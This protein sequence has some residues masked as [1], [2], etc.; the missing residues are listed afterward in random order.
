MRTKRSKKL[1]IFCAQV[2]NKIHHS[3]LLQES[4]EFL[5]LRPGD[6]VLDGTLGLGGHA[7][8]ILP[9]IGSGSYYGFDLD[10]DNIAFARDR[11]EPFAP[12]VTFLHDNFVHCHHRL[13]ELGVSRVDKILLDL[14]LSS[15]H[16]DDA[17]RGF[18]FRQDGPLDMRFDRS[19]EFT[20]ADWLNTVSEAELRRIFYDYGQEPYAPKLARM[21]VEERRLH[22]F[23]RTSQV[24]ELISRIMKNPH[25]QRKVATRLF[26]ALRIA[27]NDELQVLEQ[28]LGHALDL[29]APDGRIVVLTYHSLEDRIVKNV[30]RDAARSGGFHLLTKKPISPSEAEVQ[31]NPRSRSAHLRALQKISSHVSPPPSIV[32]S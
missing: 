32:R 12:R 16:V 4:L 21:V 8:A 1:Y 14:G 10:Q 20:A 23:D 25:D 26:Q 13:S 27:V 9:L 29:L 2:L 19:A 30:F 11:L 15:P 18:S 24:V 7:E 5:A 22:L 6:V 17:E 3:V 31:F 28:A